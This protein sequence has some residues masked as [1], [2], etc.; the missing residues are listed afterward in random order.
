VL[1][2]SFYFQTEQAELLVQGQGGLMGG[3]VSVCSPPQGENIHFVTIMCGG[4]VGFL[5][6]LFT[7]LYRFPLIPSLLREFIM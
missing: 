6:L 5:L 4:Q 3:D 1:F 2:L 7:G